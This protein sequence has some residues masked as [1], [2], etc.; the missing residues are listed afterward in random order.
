MSNWRRIAHIA[1]PRNLKGSLIVHS[2]DG[3]PFLLSAGMHV[4][5]VPPTRKGPRE[6]DVVSVAQ[7][8]DH[9]WDVRFSGIDDRAAADLVSGSYCL[10]L[11]S[12][13]SLT[14]NFDEILEGIIGWDVIDEAKGHLGTVTDIIENP[15]QTLI[16]VQTPYGDVFIPAVDEF[17]VDINEDDEAIMVSI[18]QS[19]IDLNA[20]GSK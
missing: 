19:L 12:D 8:N 4:W 5:F 3:L 2:T 15:M 6:A 14:E 1:K 9:E 17:I 13:L 11:K 10:V 20:E 7:L 16:Q 18:P